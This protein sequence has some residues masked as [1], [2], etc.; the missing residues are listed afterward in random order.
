MIDQSIAT[1][2]GKRATTEIVDGRVGMQAQADEAS[3]HVNA[4][5][6]QPLL[7]D[8]PVAA[9]NLSGDEFSA[10]VELT[11]DALDELSAALDEVRSSMEGD[12]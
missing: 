9:L 8:E 10:R 7:E 5:D 4:A 2:I 12:R 1:V 6:V 3:I 11:P